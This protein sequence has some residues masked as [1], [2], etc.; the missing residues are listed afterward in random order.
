MSDKSKTYLFI[1][2]D[3]P[4]GNERPYNALRLALDL[5]KR[6]EVQVRVFLI[7]DGVNCALAGQKTPEGYYNIERML[8]SIARR[9]EVAT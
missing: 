1:T 8:K 7:G 4:Y 5:V 9:G 6:P 3:A 2:N